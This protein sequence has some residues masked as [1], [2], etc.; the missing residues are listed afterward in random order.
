M[1][2]AVTYLYRS[3]RDNVKEMEQKRQ[4]RKTYDPTYQ[5]RRSRL[6]MFPAKLKRESMGRVLSMFKP[7]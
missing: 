7:R 4:W 2:T 3:S 1:K 6:S 5:S